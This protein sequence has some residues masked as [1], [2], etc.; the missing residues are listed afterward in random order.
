[1]TRFAQDRLVRR[2]L[3]FMPSFS[4]V[5]LLFGLVL[6]G[7][8]PSAGA[9]MRVFGLDRQ[10]RPRPEGVPAEGVAF[11]EPGGGLRRTTRRAA[12]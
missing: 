12:P 3:G 9:Q 5:A 1:M 8:A 2:R 6:G 7:A 10:F 4:L 11:S